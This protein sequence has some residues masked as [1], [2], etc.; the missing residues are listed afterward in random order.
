MNKIH[1]NGT[2]LFRF[3]TPFPHCPSRYISEGQ[4]GENRLK[5]ELAWFLTEEVRRAKPETEPLLIDLWPAR[6]TQISGDSK[7]VGPLGRRAGVNALPEKGRQRAVRSE[8]NVGRG[9]AKLFPLRGA[10]RGKSGVFS[11]S[12]ALSFLKKTRGR[13]HRLPSVDNIVA[14]KRCR[15]GSKGV[16]PLGRRTLLGIREGEAARRERASERWK[17]EGG[18]LSPPRRFV[19]AKSSRSLLP[20]SCILHTLSGRESRSILGRKE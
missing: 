9:K 5:A 14:E 18:A 15:G 3:L 2:A 12:T 4:W 11:G 17:G 13:F 20:F 7:G 16:C 8:A 19:K 6:R 10:R 1:E